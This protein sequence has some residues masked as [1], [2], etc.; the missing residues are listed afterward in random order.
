MKQLELIFTD[1]MAFCDELIVDYGEPV[2][3]SVE[4]IKKLKADIIYS[5]SNNNIFD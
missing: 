4:E 5:S 2:R 1:L 3:P